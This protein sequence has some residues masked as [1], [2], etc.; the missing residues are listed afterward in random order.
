M[1]RTIRTGHL[2][3]KK[4]NGL[5]HILRAN[6]LLKYVNEKQIEGTVSSGRRRKHIL[7]DLKATR[8]H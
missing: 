2:K 1:N 8:G 5:N 4:A 6:C 7:D 3:K